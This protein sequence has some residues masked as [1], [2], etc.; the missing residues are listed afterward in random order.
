V[1]QIDLRDAVAVITG[2]SGGLGQAVAARMAL[3]GA[4][5]VLWD[6]GAGASAPPEG[7]AAL[8]VDVTDEAQ[9]SDATART[10]DHFGRLDIL[11][12]AAG[13]G[14]HR[15]LVEDYPAEAFRSILDVNVVGTFLAC[16]HAVR[17]MRQTGSGRIVNIASVA[18]R[19]GNP[20]ASAYA[21]SKA[22]VIAFTRSLANELAT[23]GIRANCVVPAAIEA[24]LFHGM[25]EAAR[26]GALQRIP[27]GRFGRPDELAAMVCWLASDECSFSNGAAFDLSGGAAL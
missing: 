12:N 7:G 23:T 14:N 5:V 24:G 11:V 27:M 3:S 4:R 22:A 19:N 25:G 10:L 1:N 9:V 16:K 21:A 15:A 17:A 8:Q 26:R 13:L 18:G 6:R 2:G 20:Y